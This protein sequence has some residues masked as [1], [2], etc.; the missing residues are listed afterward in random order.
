L[1]WV[2]G[3][4]LN[5]DLPLARVPF[6]RGSRPCGRKVAAQAHEDPAAQ[7]PVHLGGGKIRGDSLG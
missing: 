1:G 3:K 6:H 4:V 2:C 5:Q 7:L